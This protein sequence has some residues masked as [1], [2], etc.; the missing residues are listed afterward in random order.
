METPMDLEPDDKVVYTK[1]LMDIM[2]SDD[3]ARRA[4]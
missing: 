2:Q 1:L 4:G 3:R